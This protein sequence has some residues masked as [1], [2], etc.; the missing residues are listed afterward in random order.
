MPQTVPHS[1]TLW[2]LLTVIYSIFQ[3]LQWKLF[4]RKS[5]P[6]TMSEE[7]HKINNLVNN[8]KYNRETV[9]PSISLFL[10]VFFFFLKTI[11]LCFCN[12]W[13]VNIHVSAGKTLDGWFASCGNITWISS[14][15]TQSWGVPLLPLVN[16]TLA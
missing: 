5:K 16:M 1:S 6:I 11:D 13:S 8:Q 4:K 15:R 14:K 12:T 10:F 2:W 9:L 7:P 3:T